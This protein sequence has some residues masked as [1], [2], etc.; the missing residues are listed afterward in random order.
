MKSQIKYILLSL[1]LLPQ[2]ALF[3]QSKTTLEIP[4][5]INLILLI[6]ALILLIPI[7]SLSNNILYAV[8][9]RMGEIFNNRANLIIS[10]ILLGF[11]TS[12]TPAYAQE[13]TAE[14]AKSVAAAPSDN[15]FTQIPFS[16]WLLI[17]TIL[18]EV[19]AITFLSMKTTSLLN[20]SAIA[21]GESTSGLKEWMLQKWAKMNNF[22]SPD[23]E[24]DLDTGHNYDGI[25]ELDNPAPA[26]FQAAFLLSILFAIGYIYR[27]HVIKS[28]PLQIE[29]Y[30]MDLKKAEAEHEAYL[31]SAGEQID[32]NNVKL[33]TG[34]DIEEGKTI[35]ATNCSPCHG[36]EAEGVNAPNLTDK[37]WLHGGSIADIFKSIKYGWVD[38]GM[39]SWKDDLNPKQI[40]QISSYIVSIRN[41]NKTTNRPTE[42]SEYTGN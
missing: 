11:I 4:N 40:A 15:I 14:T 32:E 12:I 6:I 24:M 27:Y 20:E 31:K 22:K 33:M 9:K 39:R 37:F 18:L 34:G 17:G 21:A 41:T 16:T 35:F 2:S 42:G 28:A 10:L 7:Y 36:K 25:R 26:W 5:G 23:K 1:C 13:A 19:I 3:A 30:T 29:E 8:K 38:K